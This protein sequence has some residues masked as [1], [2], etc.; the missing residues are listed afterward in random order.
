MSTSASWAAMH[1]GLATRAG[2]AITI[3]VRFRDAMI[4]LGLETPHAAA[5][6]WT[7]LAGRLRMGGGG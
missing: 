3:D 2:V 4:A 6:L 7:V 1:P 5:G